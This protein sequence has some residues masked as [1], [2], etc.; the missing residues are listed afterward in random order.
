MLYP[1]GTSIIII[2]TEN[3]IDI[4]FIKCEFIQ[5]GSKQLSVNFKT[6]W[7]RFKNYEMYHIY[8]DAR[9]TSASGVTYAR[10]II[11]CLIVKIL[12]ALF[13]QLRENDLRN[14]L[15]SRFA[16]KVIFI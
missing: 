8:N 14:R 9:M 16:V 1:V 5:P 3:K 4:C 15:I 6:G 2:D 10:D 11:Y 7:T 12:L 13:T